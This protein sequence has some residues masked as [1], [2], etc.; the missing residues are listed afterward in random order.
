MKLTYCPTHVTIDAPNFGSENN[1]RFAK[2]HNQCHYHLALHL[3]PTSVLQH[4]LHFGAEHE[5]YAFGASEV[6]V[7]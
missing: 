5:A 2:S 7:G 4:S 1:S 6:D 3:N